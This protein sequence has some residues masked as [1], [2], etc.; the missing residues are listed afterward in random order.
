MIHGLRRIA[1]FGCAAGIA[2]AVIPL[3]GGSAGA[4]SVR[5]Q[6]FNKSAAL[7]FLRTTLRDV[8]IGSPIKG[9]H[10]VTK[11][12]IKATAVTSS[13]W[14]GYADLSSNGSTYS[15]VKGQWKEPKVTCSAS[16]S[17]LALAAFW[18]GIDGFSSQTVEQDGT[19]AECSGAT[20]L[21][22]A[23]WWE[24]YPTNSVQIVN[25]VSPGDEIVAQVTL[26]SSTYTLRV[27]DKTDSADSFSTSQSCGGTAC[28]DSSA[29]WIGEAPCCSGSSVYP[30]PHFSTWRVSDGRAT[31]GG[32]NATI[33]GFPY[34]SI[35]MTGASGDALA[36]PSDLNA[37]GGSFGDTWHASS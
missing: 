7:A 34:D 33:S 15:M 30:L 29:E 21:G 37:T 19:I 12:G 13:N 24:M 25:S 8:K 11:G 18:V 28:D 22:Y 5:T 4:A 14:S 9:L 35:T 10:I 6:S 31:S 1:A 26:K 20:L 23:D 17:G 3:T 32:Q 2:A 36:E 16:T 27:T